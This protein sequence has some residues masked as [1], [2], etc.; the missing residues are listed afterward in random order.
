MQVVVCGKAGPGPWESL[1]ASLHSWENVG[2]SVW[3]QTVG[4]QFP[5]FQISNGI[6]HQLAPHQLCGP[7]AKTL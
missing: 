5:A 1:N 4:A 6:S 7:T 2:A 3:E